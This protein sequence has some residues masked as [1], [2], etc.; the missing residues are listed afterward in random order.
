MKLKIKPGILFAD[1]VMIVSIE[2][3]TLV[4]GRSVYE[5]G[6]MVMLEISH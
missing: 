5:S 3:P 6:A 2:L 1:N 4:T